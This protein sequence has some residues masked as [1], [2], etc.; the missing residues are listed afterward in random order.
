MSEAVGLPEVVELSIIVA[1]SENGV[2]GHDG[3]MP[4]RLS[5]DLKRFKQL[6]LGHTIVMGRKTWDSI[7]RLLPGRTTVILTR[8]PD[9]E[10]PRAI[11]VGSLQDAI[12]AT[13]DPEPFVVG[14]AEIYRLA[15]PF[16]SKLYLTRVA[17]EIEGDTFFPEFDTQQ[18]SLISEEAVPQGEKDSHRTLFQTYA[19]V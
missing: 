3:G 10:V 2:I 7:G 1:V 11:I 18:W 19:R 4:W 13:D 15:L 17:A 14:G 8:Q 9:F 16:A 12:G 6:T 5:S